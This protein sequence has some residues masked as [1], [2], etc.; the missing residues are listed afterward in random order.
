VIEGSVNLSCE[1]AMESLRLRQAERDAT[2]QLRTLHILSF[3]EIKQYVS[4]HI[5][6]SSFN[7]NQIQGGDD[8]ALAEREP[9][10]ERWELTIW[11]A[12][13]GDEIL[14]CQG[15]T[16]NINDAVFAAP[17]SLTRRGS[18]FSTPRSNLCSA[19]QSVEREPAGE[20]LDPSRLHLHG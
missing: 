1:V 3:V 17:A 4:N 13:L 6:G 2:G 9:Q 12:Q 5:H 19:I 10:P 15:N 8:L 14:T 16:K 11:L 18:C 20:I 7:M